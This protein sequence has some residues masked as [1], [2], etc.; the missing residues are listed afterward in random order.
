[1]SA[2]RLVATSAAIVA[3]LAAASLAAAAPPPPIVIDP[4]PLRALLEQRDFDALE[5][6]FAAARAAPDSH[7]ATVLLGKFGELTSAQHLG[8]EE[9]ASAR[10]DSVAA[11]LALAQREL[12]RAWEA[13]GTGYAHTV[14]GE[15]R[16]AMS[17]RLGRALALAAEAAERD[18]RWLDARR[19]QIQ[20]AQLT[21]DGAFARSAFEAALAV[22]PTHY[23]VWSGYQRLFRRR[24]GG[25]YEA[26][27]E[28]ARVAQAHADAN[29]RLRR[30][31]GAADADRAQDLWSAGRLEEALAAYD[32]ALPHGDDGALRVDRSGVRAALDDAAG[33]RAE[34]ESGLAI[35]PYFAGLHATLARR[36]MSDH[37]FAC[38]V[39]AA[40]RAIALEPADPEHEKLRAFGAWAVEHPAAAV[41]A[42]ENHPVQN[43]L[44]RHRR[45]L[46]LH[47]FESAAIAAL[48][49]IGWYA[50]RA[51]RRRAADPAAAPSV[52]APVSPLTPA[53]E[54]PSMVE[55]L[56]RTGVLMIRAFVWFELVRFTLYYS[57]RWRPGSSQRMLLAE[58]VMSA[59][60]LAGAL[61]FAHGIRLG[62]SWIWK[63][64]AL[65][66]PVWTQWLAIHVHGFTW[67]Q[68]SIWGFWHLILLPVYA[69]LFL[70]GYRCAALWQGGLPGPGWSSADAPARAPTPARRARG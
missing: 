17:A 25:S 46:Y 59:V 38:M 10:P 6:R 9:W 12:A 24:W 53:A 70:Y 64:W 28:I 48:I 45:W 22:D 19:I 49:G 69:S 40:E 58:I 41:R 2:C 34:I 15:A 60:A 51:R 7:E 62:G 8:L 65:V 14:D 57:E 5:A 55:R 54:R 16:R 52:R 29:P 11:R 63:L 27:E 18:P 42:L 37:D 47:A 36:C 50:L 66:Y 67:E 20:C 3:V 13:R 4:L 23:G 43:W 30:L 33:A 31:L 32:R 21:G 26:Q 44:A 56:P 68:W 39:K 61:A 1:M 35:D